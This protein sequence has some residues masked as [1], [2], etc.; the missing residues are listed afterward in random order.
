MRPVSSKIVTRCLRGATFKPTRK[1]ARSISAC[2]TVGYSSRSS[3]VGE[4]ESLFIFVCLAH[5]NDMDF[6]VRFGMH[7]HDDRD[8]QQPECDPTLFSVVLTRIFK[9][10]GRTRE[11][12]FRL[13]EIHAM[14]CQVLLSFG[15]VPGKLHILYYAYNHAYRNTSCSSPL[16]CVRRSRALSGASVLGCFC[17]C[18]DNRLA[19]PCAPGH[20]LCPGGA[21]SSGMDVA[22]GMQGGWGQRVA[23]GAS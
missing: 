17:L 4:E 13:R 14:F 6:L 21:C 7:D 22:M 5:R 23:W 3:E 12:P 11:H 16:S 1:A 9:R 15:F 2:V 10:E 19:H 18:T 20:G 8:T